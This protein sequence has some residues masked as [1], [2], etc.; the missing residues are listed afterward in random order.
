MLLDLSPQ[1]T[2]RVALT[3]LWLSKS[4]SLATVSHFSVCVLTTLDIHSS[5]SRLGSFTVNVRMTFL[6]CDWGLEI[7]QKRPSIFIL[8]AFS[9]GHLRSRGVKRFQNRNVR[10]PHHSLL[11][12]IACLLRRLVF[13]EPERRCSPARWALCSTNSVLE[14]LCILS[15]F[16]GLKHFLCKNRICSYS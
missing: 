9:S 15:A 16:G 12:C 8:V 3:Y 7:F 11:K 4:L 13:G 6:L 5:Y 1:R 14:Y 2:R 10:A